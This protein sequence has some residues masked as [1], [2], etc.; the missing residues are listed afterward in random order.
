MWPDYMRSLWSTGFGLRSQKLISRDEAWLDVYR[1]V[2]Q[3]VEDGLHR[4][5]DDAQLVEHLLACL[6]ITGCL[7][8]HD[9][10]RQVRDVLL[11]ALHVD[12]KRPVLRDGHAAVVEEVIELNRHAA[13]VCLGDAEADRAEHR[14]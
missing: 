6:R 11:D 5:P 7:H 2:L 10:T 3:P 1:N 13:A 12:G 9:V 4:R 14:R 8:R